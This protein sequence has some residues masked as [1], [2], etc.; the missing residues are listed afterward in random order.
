MYYHFGLLCAFRP[1]ISLSAEHPNMQPSNIC[2]QSA[3]SIL[4]LAQSYD[5][6]FTLRRVSALIP[7]FVCT[8]GLFSLALEGDGSPLDSP[9][10]N[11]IQLKEYNSVATNHY[12]YS[13]TPSYFKISA[14]VHAS[15]LLAK[16]SST[17]P[18]ASSAHKAL[19]EP[20]EESL[21]EMRG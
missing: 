2:K 8:S 16:M 3:Q 14:T 17:H 13:A 6:L 19:G 20:D 11:T 21:L 7:Y 1:F 10:L 4:A 15:L 9:S 5:D 18:A 12:G